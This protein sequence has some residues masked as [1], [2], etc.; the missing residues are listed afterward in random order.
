M[1]RVDLTEG[2]VIGKRA[3]HQS[4]C[5]YV[6]SRLMEDPR[7]CPKAPLRRQCQ[8]SCYGGGGFSAHT[9]QSPTV[10]RIRPHR[11]G[12]HRP[13]R[14]R[15]DL[16]ALVSVL[17][18]PLCGWN[19]IRFSKPGNGD[20]Y[21]ERRPR[22]ATCGTRLSMAEAVIDDGFGLFRRSRLPIRRLLLRAKPHYSV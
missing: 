12:L 20:V 19:Q 1:H 3:S 11:A 10:A 4:G 2:A 8:K 17:Y 9:G 14:V 13:R 15:R 5:F 18:A 21:D 6:G 16:P 7:P 22:A